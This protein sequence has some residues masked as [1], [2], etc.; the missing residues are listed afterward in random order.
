ME[1]GEKMKLVPQPQ[2][3]EVSGGEFSLF[4]VENVIIEEKCDPRVVGLVEKFCQ[5][6]TAL[7]NKKIVINSKSNTGEV[8][9]NIS[10]GDCGEEYSSFRLSL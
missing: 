7:T 9:I 1:K 6:F 3:I 10:H 2:K 4:Q 5:E 8:G